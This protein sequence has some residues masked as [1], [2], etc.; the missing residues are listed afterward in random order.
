[1]ASSGQGD[2]K[3]QR[4]RV[5]I[6]W[7]AAICS[8]T[9]PVIVLPIAVM[10]FAVVNDLP[11]YYAGASLVA[12][13]K[14]EA[15]YQLGMLAAE[16]Q[17]IFPAM[18]DRIVG[19]FIPPFAVPLLMPLL[20]IPP[21]A[22]PVV[23][24]TFLV[25]CVAAACATLRKTFQLSRV[26]TL[27]LVAVL[28]LS[29]P[30]YEALRIGQLA[31]L[32]LLALCAATYHL[33]KRNDTVAGLWLA[34]LLLKPQELLPL[35]LY[36]AAGRKWKV[37]IALGLSALLLCAISLIW[38]GIEAWKSYSVLISDVENNTRFMQPELS[39]TLRG[40]LLRFN[41][42]PAGTTN[43]ISLA[44][45]SISLLFIA[46]CGYKLRGDWRGLLF[47]ALPLGLV[48]ALH[49]HDYDLLLLTPCIVSLTRYAPASKI[50]ALLQL[51]GILSAGLFM[52]PFYIP[53]HYQH[54]L[55]GGLI[56]PQFI[57]LLV[58]AAAL[59]FFT[60][61]TL[62]GFLLSDGTE[63]KAKDGPEHP[64]GV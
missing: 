53:I 43:L 1:M 35:A 58:W 11:E 12:A 16:E 29:G 57:V 56:N 27:W 10:T 28:C 38:P 42:I 26:A 44:G 50:P 49:C 25:G 40:Q 60:L 59:A 9:V 31:P 24:T 8:L 39:S 45:L 62:P 47:I 2:D 19:L 37:I 33:Q 52:L 64:P 18:G 34:I 36:L 48:F 30:L 3:R 15:I 13:G 22:A 23:W 21:L 51:A 55:K 6:A 41:S 46:G 7:L 63:G 61:K 54:L 4:F 17:R 32:L 14:G 5:A 20:L